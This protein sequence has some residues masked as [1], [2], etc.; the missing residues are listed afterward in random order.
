MN[1]KII[2]LFLLVLTG[3]FGSTVLN[4]LNAPD[5][6]QH[7]QNTTN[8][9]TWVWTDN[10]NDEQGF[11]CYEWYWDNTLKRY[12]RSN[13]P[14]W[15]VNANITSY[16]ETGLNPNTQYRRVIVAW[17]GTSEEPNAI[18]DYSRGHYYFPPVDYPPPD[19]NPPDYLVAYYTSIEPPSGLEFG[20]KGITQL[21]V[22]LKEPL[23][24]NITAT[25]TYF[26]YFN[27][28]Y[29][30]FFIEN[31][32][33]GKN[34]GDTLF[35][36]SPATSDGWWKLNNDYDPF[37]TLTGP[38]KSSVYWESYQKNG[39][40]S[41]NSS[42]STY[43][44]NHVWPY[45]CVEDLEPNTPYTFR[46]KARNGD[47]DETSWCLPTSQVWTYPLP[48]DISYD[49]PDGYCYAQGTKFTFTSNI[50]F[51]IGT[52]DHYHILWTNSPG[53]IP[54]EE[55]TK[56]AA[57]DWIITENRTGDWYLV[58]MSHNAQHEEPIE[59][60]M[61]RAFQS[62]DGSPIKAYTYV[63]YEK[64]IY[65]T[66]HYYDAPIRNFHITTYGPFKIGYDVHGKVTISG[67]T[68]SY[69]DVVVHCGGYTT[70][71]DSE[72][73]YSFKN[74]PA[75][76]YDVYAELTGY[77]I[78]YP[79]ENGGH[80]SIKLPDDKDAPSYVKR[81]IDF[82]L[83]YKN[84][85]TIAGKV[86]FIGGPGGTP[87]DVTR[88]KITCGSYTPVYPDSKG[89]FYI[90]GVFAG[91]YKLKAT[92]PASDSDY[93]YY[94]V[95]FP[96]GGEYT[97]SVGP[98]AT[99][100]DFIFTWTQSIETAN[101]S[102]KV[103]L[104]GGTGDPSKAT[105][106]CKNLNTGVSG[107]TNPDHTG[108]YQ[109]A[110]LPK[111]NSYELWVKMD[112]YKTKRVRISDNVWSDTLI[113][114]TVSNLQ[115]DEPNKDFELSPISYYSV[116]GKVNVA[117]GVIKP[118]DVKLHLD[119]TSDTSILFAIHPEVDGS[120]VFS[121][122][123]EGTYTLYAE[124]PSGYKVTNPVSGKYT[125]IVLGPDAYGYNF[126]IEPTAKYSVSGKVTLQ[127]GTCRPTEALVVCQYYNNVKKEYITFSTIPDL[128]GNYK[129]SN[130]VPANYT[131]YVSL[132]GYL[133]LYPTSGNYSV[134]ITNK[135]IT[136]KD[137]YLASYAI[138]GNVRFITPAMEPVTNVIIV[139]SA[140]S[141][142]PDVPSVYK[143]TH[144][145]SGGNYAFYNLMPSAKLA[146]PGSGKSVPYRVEAF[147]EGYGTILPSSGYYDVYITNKDE[148]KD[149]VLGTYTVSGK[150]S[151]YS[152]TADL[153]KA[154]VTAARLTAAG[155]DEV[156]WIVTNPDSS[157]AYQINGLKAGNY[158]RIRVKLENFYSL[159]P[160]EQGANW[161]YE[162][163]VPPS[164]TNIDFI[165][166]PANVPSVPTCTISGNVSIPLPITPD[167]VLVH[168]G[169][170][171]TYPDRSGNYYFKNLYP[172][173]YDVWVE[174][175]GYKT[176]YPTTNG[177]HYYVVINE[178]DNLKTG[179]NFVLAPEPVP[180]YK[181]S[182]TV[183]LVGGTGD[184]RNVVVHC[185]N[186]TA[187]PNSNGQYSF[188]N[189]PEGSY[190]LWVELDKYQ[191]TNPGGTGKQ[192]IKLYDRDIAGVD[193]T[194]QAIPTYSIKGTVT[195]SDGDVTKVNIVCSSGAVVNPDSYGRYI[196]S[197]LLA[198]TYEVYAEM[199]GYIV[200]Y[201]KNNLYRVKLG[202]DAQNCD[203]TI[204]RTY[205]I[206][207]TIK[208]NGGTGSLTSVKVY[209]NNQ[210]KN[211]D[212]SGYYEFTGLLPGNYEVYASL[213][214]Y[215]IV[216]PSSG[217]YKIT[218][219]PDATLKDFTMNATTL[220]S[221]SGNVK[222]LNG[223]G[224]VTDVVV[225]TA[226]LTTNPD[227]NGN[228]TISGL[229][230]GT[231]N[232]TASLADYTVVA[233]P[234]TFHKITL[235]R[236]N[237]TNYNFSLATYSIS[238]NVKV[239]G[240]G[241][242]QDVVISCDDGITQRTTKPDENG[243]YIFPQLPAGKY[244]IK[245]TLANFSILLPGGDGIYTVQVGPSSKDKNFTF[246]AYSVSGRASF[247]G[248]KGN[249]TDVSIRCT[250]SG[251]DI[252]VNPDE[253]GYYKIEPLPAG[254]YE[255]LA[256]I[257]GYTVVSPNN[258]KHSFTLR[259]NL[260]E[261]NFIISA[262]YISGRVSLVNSPNTVTNVTITLT[263]PVGTLNTSPNEKGYYEFSTLPAGTY[264][265][266]ASLSNHTLVSP[267]AG[268]YQITIP[269][270]ATDKNFT[271]VAYSISGTVRVN[272]ASG[273]AGTTIY[274]EGPV[275][276]LT[277]TVGTDGRFEFYPLPAGDY[278]L[279]A[280]KPGYKTTYPAE[281]VYQFKLGSMLTKNFVLQ[282]R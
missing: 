91:A 178:T 277:F 138:K 249:I 274:C 80:Y 220:L 102:G 265:I 53:A 251:I 192:T 276:T 215:S 132:T 20:P 157:G 79:V 246:V 61:Q 115:N 190:E 187:N 137:F 272:D 23:P 25:G 10:S 18:Y 39:P 160:K 43:T 107:T 153:T 146:K 82:T 93:E 6:L 222:I 218:L 238:G 167:R 270:N 182:G 1:K 235:S 24:S 195:I 44:A 106:Y 127:G 7:I 281:E 275:G 237:L 207:G 255:L 46:A 223:T 214:G 256:T 161:G 260:T 134:T 104:I 150:L 130:L 244:V 262:F 156:E 133:T 96:A 227:E 149:F 140:K 121:N 74:L 175:M 15:S 282:K 62:I 108:S 263:G 125:G 51:G 135:D 173:T 95:T 68:G 111:D 40:V 204:A 50:P 112:G 14:I 67:G 199:P 47:K 124:I 145:D 201:P 69:T 30:G 56:W 60:N 254:D 258:G 243:N 78:A 205:T 123:P 148:I 45:L 198:G 120:F 49:K 253:K 34:I 200:T 250:G 37:S 240:K 29:S 28:N 186:M 229:S 126:L 17:K 38:S 211:P 193:F 42:N 5:P 128:A 239:M 236:T 159:R 248:T 33:T 141:D 264:T 87:S 4:A 231:Y 225:S 197:D 259:S 154:T 86:T 206:S 110:G 54:T 109:F 143:I 41:Y 131:L 9:I 75:G 217:S 59:Y 278:K 261:K 147:L 202:P 31:I 72:G 99:G 226:G 280:E 188:T 164:A 230:P 252:T 245:A 73:L 271:I 90:P 191:T 268:S 219:G 64:P 116:S 81:N 98:D 266:T 3:F 208:L 158:Y 13:N 22:R 21:T 165:M 101:I 66:Y 122:V 92:L 94:D 224:K 119:C 166:Y 83:A 58:V 52:V 89:N 36:G 84:T 19:Y 269:Q 142:N 233:P 213:D 177:G 194:M 174:R 12:I 232:L 55:S 172:G 267:S 209:C 16:V 162:I 171:K 180:T 85:Y 168:C 163:R 48:P 114:I 155:G 77:R 8:S 70:K 210:V 179:I 144:P 242:V 228:Y 196:I 26:G 100:K 189:L 234:A 203:F 170:Y 65:K 76:T 151:L 221:V 181:I 71:C 169:E 2:L 183:Y 103:N 35:M 27:P 212:T 97:I 247:Y 139:C 241:N 273:P 32:E 63:K 185:N 152:G 11:R 118:P 184:V 88:V 257:P 117:E 57:G 279:W 129:F 136:G 176:T 113:K 105:V 216:F